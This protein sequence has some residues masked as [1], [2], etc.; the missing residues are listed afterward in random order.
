VPG[1]YSGIM[2]LGWLD[3]P[4]VTAAVAAALLILARPVGAPPD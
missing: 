1:F 3:G 2:P 4:R